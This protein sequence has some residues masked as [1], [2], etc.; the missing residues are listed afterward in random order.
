MPTEE[1][2]QRIIEYHKKEAEDEYHR[3]VG[4]DPIYDEITWRNV[5]PFLP[6]QGWILDWRWR[7]CMVFE[8]DFINFS[9]LLVASNK[10]FRK[11]QSTFVD[12]LHRFFP[13]HCQVS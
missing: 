9:F 12:V 3:K 11:P 6:K 10:S 5:E 1:H 7:G 4:Y 13:R 8:D 2:I